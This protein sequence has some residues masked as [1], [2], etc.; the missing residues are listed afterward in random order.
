MGGCVF[1]QGASGETRFPWR[2]EGLW[3][4][5]SW[6]GGESGAAFC[7]VARSRAGE[8]HSPRVAPRSRVGESHSPRVAP[9]SRV[10]ERRS[11]RLTP[12]SRAGER[13][14]PR[15][16]PR[17]RSDETRAARVER[18]SPSDE[19]RAVRVTRRSRSDEPLQRRL[20]SRGSTRVRQDSRRR[21]GVPRDCPRYDIPMSATEHLNLPAEY[22]P[23]IRRI[24][25]GSTELAF[26]LRAPW[27]RVDRGLHH[28]RLLLGHLIVM[29]LRRDHVWLALDEERFGGRGLASWREGTTPR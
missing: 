9:Q 18:K 17:F 6:W 5:F 27:C 2:F 24:F 23:R 28:L 3:A 13:D 22:A 16:T 29:T 15:V 25:G 7:V 20:V 10:G 19:T 1:F 14:S 11:P 26:G 8:S 12:R 4:L 21:R